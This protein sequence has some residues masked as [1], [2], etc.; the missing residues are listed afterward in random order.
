VCDGTACHVRHSEKLRYLVREK[1]GLDDSKDTTDDLGFT[2]ET[3]SCIGACGLAPVVTVNDDEVYGQ[4]TPEA[5]AIVL[6]QLI[7]KERAEQ[8]TEEQQEKSD[9]RPAR[10]GQ[11][12]SW[13]T[14]RGV[15]DAEI[16]EGC[17]KNC[18]TGQKGPKSTE[19]AGNGLR[20]D[21]VLSQRITQSIREA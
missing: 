18:G 16:S 7:A 11:A 17:R 2:L 6:D 9:Q 13:T 20:R 1:L 21:R 8:Q 10:N 19:G 14:G 12:K 4:M 3:V 15:K 5:L